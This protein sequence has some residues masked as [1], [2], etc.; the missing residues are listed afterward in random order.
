MSNTTL[1]CRRA[2]KRWSSKAETSLMIHLRF[3]LILSNIIF[4]F[5]PSLAPPHRR[6]SSS[7]FMSVYTLFLMTEQTLP[8]C[9][10]SRSHDDGSLCLTGRG[11]R[12]VRHPR[13]AQR[14][15]R[16]ED[17]GQVFVAQVRLSTSPFNHAV[18]Q[19][20]QV[21]IKNECLQ[22]DEKYKYTQKLQRKLFYVSIRSCFH[23]KLLIKLMCKIGISHKTFANKAPFPSSELALYIIIFVCN[24]LRASE[25]A[26]ETRLCYLIFGACCLGTQF[27]ELII[28]KLKHFRMTKLAFQMLC[29][30][31]GPLVGPVLCYPIAKSHW[32]DSVKLFPS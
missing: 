25:C 15:Q 17:H 24:K 19:L 5:P 1:L 30:E 27:W 9:W 10:L 3:C 11:R 8:W 22:N 32:C 18:I 20:L 16:P 21:E 2:V 23:S 31:I 29:N 12:E 14:A 28:T 6:C 4:V 26:D 13:G 7:R